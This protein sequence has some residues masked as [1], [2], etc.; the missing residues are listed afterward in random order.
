MDSPVTTQEIKDT[1]LGLKKAQKKSK[2]YVNMLES[3]I[4]SNERCLSEKPELSEQI[5][6]DEAMV[7]II[8]AEIAAYEAE[9]A[10]YEAEIAAYEAEIATY[11]AEIA[12]YEA[13]IATYEA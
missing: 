9:I 11:E 4:R 12:T 1:I 10:A 13:E 6:K 2:N 5:Q 7:K 8:E 3:E